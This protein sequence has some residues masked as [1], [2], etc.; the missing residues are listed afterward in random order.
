MNP[1]PIFPP[2]GTSQLVPLSAI[3]ADER[4]QARV[5]LRPSVVRA[6]A[7]AMKQ[8]VREGGLRFPAVVLFRYGERYILAD[9]FHRILAAR[10][11]GLSEF[12]ADVRPGNERDALLHSISANAGHGLPRS[13][14]DK[15]KAVLLL[16]ADPELCTW[17]DHEIA[18]HCQVS[19]RFVGKIRH[20]ASVNGSQIGPRKVKRGNTVYEM[21]PRT[22]SGQENAPEQCAKT[23]VTPV[24]ACDRVGLPLPADV[25]PA[26]AFVGDFE[27]AMRLL[28][29]LAGLVDRLGQGAGGVAYR[30]HLTCRASQVQSTFFS[31]ELT[32]VARQ[33]AAAPHCGQC[34]RCRLRT[35]IRLQP[36][37]KLCGGRG[38]LT[39]A[40]FDICTHQERQELERLRSFSA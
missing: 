14:A 11:A 26:F 6:Y 27:T 32:A 39:K 38:W 34:P 23:T 3:P 20:G 12:P 8:Q 18:R 19:C 16:L 25:V 10:E 31:P 29:Q 5:K 21:Q 30:L 17:S 35:A 24:P 4:A 37:C 15:R 2:S 7:Q 22:G 1:A 36:T 13:N 40:E 9:G 28:D 33:L